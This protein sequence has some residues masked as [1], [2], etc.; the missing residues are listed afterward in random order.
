MDRRIL[1]ELVD[2]ILR[3]VNNRVLSIIFYG[4]AARGTNTDGSDVD[5]AI[6]MEGNLDGDTEEKLSDLL[7]I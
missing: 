7:L 6:L 1:M 5:I 3:I 2:G 4:S